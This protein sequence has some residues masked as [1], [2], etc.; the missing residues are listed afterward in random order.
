MVTCGP[1]FIK[2]LNV[3]VNEI[4]RDDNSL[5]TA[6]YSEELLNGETT[7]NVISQPI[8]YPKMSNVINMNETND[9]DKLLRITNCLCLSIYK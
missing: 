2:S 1:S 8:E 7:V 6:T 9:L 5:S 3:K 4:A